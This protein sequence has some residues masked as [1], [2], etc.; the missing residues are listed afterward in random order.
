MAHGFG[1]GSFIKELGPETQ[2]S[3]QVSYK[4]QNPHG[5]RD[6]ACRIYFCVPPRVTPHCHLL[7]GGNY[8][9]VHLF[10]APTP[11][12]VSLWFSI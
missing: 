11:A 1:T 5:F 9:G 4:M 12:W 10:G 3:I 8:L 7:A 6:D 2:N